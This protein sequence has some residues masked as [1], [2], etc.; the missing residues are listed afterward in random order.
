MKPFAIA[1]LAASLALSSCTS[2]PS[3]ILDSPTTDSPDS[4]YAFVFLLAGPRESELTSEELQAARTGHRANITRLAEEG[5]LLIAGPLF[6]PRS[7]LAHR[8]IF[9]FDI[10]DIDEALLIAETDPSVQL[11]AFALAV[12]PF[13]SPADLRRVAEIERAA[14]EAK[15]LDPN[16]PMPKA[17]AYMLA[18]ADTGSATPVMEYLAQEGTAFFHGSFGGELEGTAIVALDATTEEDAQALLADAQSVTGVE[19]EWTLHGWYSTDSV[20][21]LAED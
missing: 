19:V 15:K 10:D 21:A 1:I 12:Y 17:R 14:K 11:G 18:T 6:D 7:D 2:A 20:A 13:R 5:V 4:M 9:I 3:A 8:G 16:A